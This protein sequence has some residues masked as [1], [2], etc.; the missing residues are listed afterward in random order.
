MNFLITN[1]KD[2]KNDFSLNEINHKNYKILFDDNWTRDKN[3]IT[4]KRIAN[5]N[6]FDQKL[7]SIPQIIL[8]TRL[9][10]CKQVFHIY[11]IRTDQRNELREHLMDS[12]IDAKIH[13]PIPMHSWL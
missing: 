5:A 8:P 9:K 7:I 4:N 13:Y 3:S 11:V 12:G 2:Y 10:E 1:D 6:Y